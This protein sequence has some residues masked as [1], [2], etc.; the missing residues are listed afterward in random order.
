MGCYW[1]ALNKKKI[2]KELTEAGKRVYSFATT[3]LAYKLGKAAMGVGIYKIQWFLDKVGSDKEDIVA[4]FGP[5]GTITMNT[6]RFESGVGYGCVVSTRSYMFPTLL[7]PNACGFGLFKI[8]DFDYEQVLKNHQEL[9]RNGVQVDDKTEVMDTSKSNHFISI[10][11]LEEVYK[12][13]YGLDQGFYVII[14][15]SPQS[16]KEKLY[17][18]D[19]GDL[20]KERTPLGEVEGLSGGGAKDYLSFFKKAEEVSKMKRIAI[21]EKL[22]GSGNVETICNPTHQGY[23][24]EG[25]R[26]TMRLGIHNSLD[27]SSEGKRL[28]PIGFNSYSPIFLYTGKKN[29]NKKF[30]TVHQLE[31][32]D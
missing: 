13:R 1:V 24:E 30:W 3:D 14:H 17:N 21:A 6:G 5:D 10:L 29:I 11:N 27:L 20:I 2:M 26:Y 18:W 4:V 23:F 19:S 28:F 22:F 12:E 31:R 7:K 25:G 8:N 15:S 32:A 16:F 9:K